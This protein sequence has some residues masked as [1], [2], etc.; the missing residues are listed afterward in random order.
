MSAD[1]NNCTEI[2]NESSSEVELSE[3]ACCHAQY[4]IYYCNFH[5]LCDSCFN[6]FDNQKMRGRFGQLRA[7]ADQG[8]EDQPKSEPEFYTESSKEFIKSGRCTHSETTNKMQNV[9]DFI[10]GQLVNDQSTK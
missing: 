7:F 8:K 2:E 3:C 1:I 5:N 10:R 4:E 6:Q 9:I